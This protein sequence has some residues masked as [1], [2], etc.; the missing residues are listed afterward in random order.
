ME[1]RDAMKAAIAMRGHLA[2]TSRII[3]AQEMGNA[4]EATNFEL[5]YMDVLQLFS[6]SAPGG[7]PR[8]KAGA[9]R[10]RMKLS[11]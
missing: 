6:A 9:S 10:R 8:A 4:A 3:I 2:L 1:A 5:P 7:S 11:N